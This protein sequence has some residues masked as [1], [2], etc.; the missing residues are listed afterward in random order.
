MSGFSTK[1]QRRR[2]LPR[3]LLDLL[4]AGIG[5]APIGDRGGKDRDIG[6][7]R[8]LDGRQHVAR[9]FDMHRVHAGRIGNVDRPA[10]QRHLGAGC[11]RR[12]C[13]GV[14]LLAG[15]AV[16]DIA[17]RIDRLVGRAGGDQHALALERLRR[18]RARAI[19][20]PARRS[21]VGSAMRP[22]PRSPASAISPSLGPMKAKP[23]ATSCARLR[24]VALFAHICGFMAGA[25][26]TFA[27]VA[28]S[29]AVARSVGQAAGDLGHQV[30]GAGRH[31]DQVG[32]ARQANM[33]D[34]ELVRGIEQIGE[35]ALAG[36]GA[37]RERR[38]EMLGRLGQ[39]AAHG[40][41]RAPSAGG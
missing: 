29:T 18:P 21:P 27:L 25:S 8:A 34:V 36:D 19:C 35:D 5:D 32:L 22:R 10:D 39:D 26:S 37:G 15:G 6:G 14:A 24:C 33:A 23:S 38:D 12:C 11:C 17:H 30:G 2:R 41:A 3:R 1:R 28:S 13:D 40:R 20:L 7:Q 31:H 16:G 4:F 9:A